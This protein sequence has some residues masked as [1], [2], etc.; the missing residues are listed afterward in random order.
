MPALVTAKNLR[1]QRANLA[2]R[3]NEILEKPAGEN[4]T[5]SAEQRTEFDRL[6]AE[7]NTLKA[8]VDRIEEH[9]ATMAEL[10]ASPGPLAGGRMGDLDGLFVADDAAMVLP[11][12]TS[13]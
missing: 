5:I 10:N 4:N 2:A 12:H 3:M 11:P 7:Q 13:V 1:A 6:H 8:D 9:E